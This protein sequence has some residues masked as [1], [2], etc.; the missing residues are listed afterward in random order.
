MKWLRIFFARGE[1]SSDVACDNQVHGI[2]N[3]LNGLNGKGPRSDRK[4]HT[5]ET[6]RDDSVHTWDFAEDKMLQDLWWWSNQAL[7][8]YCHS[9]EPICFHQPFLSVLKV[10]SLAEASNLNF[11]QEERRR[12]LRRSAMF[13]R[14]SCDDVRVAPRRVARVSFMRSY[15]RGS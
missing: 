6:R 10:I 9:Q 11:F 7:S 4:M 15:R 12:C 3:G 14:N 13:G 8:G 1:R 5:G 2:V